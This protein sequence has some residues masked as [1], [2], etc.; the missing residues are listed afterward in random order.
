[1]LR[2]LVLASAFLTAA[3][4]PLFAQATID[5]TRGQVRMTDA[6]NT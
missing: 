5:P 2:K 4:A 3:T 1:M 6:G